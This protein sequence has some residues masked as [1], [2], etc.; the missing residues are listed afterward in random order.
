M[1]KIYTNHSTNNLI[2]EYFNARDIEFDFISSQDSIPKEDQLN[3]YI[4]N[5]QNQKVCF[6]LTKIYFIDLLVHCKN[7]DVFDQSTVVLYDNDMEPY[8]S[9]MILEDPKKVEFLNSKL[10]K[11]ITAFVDH[12][13]GKKVR[14]V[15][16]NINFEHFNY[17]NYSQFDGSF[18]EALKNKQ[19][20]KKDY[21]YAVIAK[22]DFRKKVLSVLKEKGLDQNS[23]NLQSASYDNKPFADLYE[24]YGKLYVDTF[25]W[26]PCLPPLNFYN[27]TNF[28]LVFECLG[29]LPGDDSFHIT[30]KVLK[31]IAMKHPFLVA[32][33]PMFLEY[34]RAEGFKTFDGIIDESYDKEFDTDTRIDMICDTIKLINTDSERIY[35]QC[36]EICEFNYD[37]YIKKLG[38]YKAILWKDYNNF[39]KKH[40]EI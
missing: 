26:H 40:L 12:K 19:T 29:I 11:K 14:D 10:T 33:T 9:Q 34:M 39:F 15:W 8:W 7:G 22:N 4:R 16:S 28:E 37:V 1:V 27:N 32:T 5:N 18:F 30:E 38:S 23:F 2:C 21:F 6:L 17:T 36:Q 35:N 31:P 13:P 25:V 3:H 20:A 24:S